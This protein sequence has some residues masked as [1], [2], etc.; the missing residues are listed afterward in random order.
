MRI[1]NLSKVYIYSP[2]K[3]LVNGE[4]FTT[5]FFK[6]EDWLNA[7]Q[8]INELNRNSAGEI[9]YEIVKLR[10]DREIDIDIDK[11]DGIS[12][13]PLEVDENKMVINGGKPDY[14]VE[15]KPKIGKT[16]LFTLATNNGE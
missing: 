8:D 2:K 11:G 7:Q 14:L 12:F 10:I 6:V 13:E 16:T 9:D 5:W 1:K 3:E 15:N 4:Y